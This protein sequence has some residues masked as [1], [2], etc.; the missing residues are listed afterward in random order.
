MSDLPHI[1]HKWYPTYYKGLTETH[2]HEALECARR[3]KRAGYSEHAK[4]VLVR[5]KKAEVAR[6]EKALENDRLLTDEELA[7]VSL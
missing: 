2:P 6:E 4:A 3:L 1:H 5:F 7:N